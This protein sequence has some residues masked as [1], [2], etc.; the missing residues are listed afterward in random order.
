[1][2]MVLSS[3]RANNK[4]RGS[5]EMVRMHYIGNRNYF[6]ATNK[7]IIISKAVYTYRDFQKFHL[8]K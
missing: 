7:K 5:S 6:K 4:N 1:M 8:S 3:V 2:L